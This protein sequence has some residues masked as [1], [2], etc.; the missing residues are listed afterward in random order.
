MY[1]TRRCCCPTAPN[2][3]SLHWNGQVPTPGQWL[4][5]PL[6]LPLQPGQFM[7]SPPLPQ[8]PPCPAGVRELWE[9]SLHSQGVWKLLMILS[10]RGAAGPTGDKCEVSPRL[11]WCCVSA[12]RTYH[13]GLWIKG[14][15][16]LWILGY[17]YLKQQPA[18]G[19]WSGMGFRR[20]W[21]TLCQNS[22]FLY[23]CMLSC[24]GQ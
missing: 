5:A 13:P 2:P 9:D 8:P 22:I 24:L 11:S 10:W 15:L 1:L 19:L 3:R 12:I 17:G 20:Q 4:P 23:S 6:L 18:E 21:H 14:G 7:A 16:S